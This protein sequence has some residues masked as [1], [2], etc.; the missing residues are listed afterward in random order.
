MQLTTRAD[1]QAWRRPSLSQLLSFSLTLSCPAPHR[2]QE[3]SSAHIEAP[4]AAYNAAVSPVLPVRAGW[5][6][7]VQALHR[8]CCIERRR[9]SG[10]SCYAS[11]RP[12]RLP[13]AWATLWGHRRWPCS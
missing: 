2:A 11:S 10:T 12:S 8:G 6:S 5:R 4:P 3:K 9:R 7:R 1:L 13:T